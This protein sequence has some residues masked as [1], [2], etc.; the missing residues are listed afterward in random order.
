LG[1]G[2]LQSNT[3]GGSNSAMGVNALQTN[4]TGNA[5]S[6]LGVNALQFNLSGSNN[7]AMGASSLNAN[8][9]GSSNT[10]LGVSALQN[11]TIGGS[12]SAM[13]MNA[14][15]TNIGGVNNSALGVNALRYNTEGSNNAAVGVS[16][17]QNNTTGGNNTAIGR[18]AGLN[19]TTSFNVVAIGFSALSSVT[20]SGQNSTAVGAFALNLATV[21]GNTALGSE[22]GLTTTTGTS[23]IYLGHRAGD[24]TAASASNR[25][26]AGSSDAAIVSV[27]IGNGETNGSPQA[28]TY[29]ATGGSGTNIGGAA[30]TLAGGRNT[31]SGVGG[32]VV[33][34]TTAVG[35][36]SATAGTLLNRFS[37]LGDGGVLWTGIATASEPAV[38]TSNNGAIFFDA[39]LQKFRVSQNGAAYVDL[40]GGGGTVTSV[41]VTTANGVSGS[42]AT[43][44]TTPAITITLGAIT[45]T[46]VAS[47]GAVS[48]TTGTFS[49]AVAGSNLSG[50]NTGDQTITLT[51]NVTGSGTGSFATTIA[52]S[53]VT[54]AMQANVATS[55]ILGRVTA[56]TG[57]VEALTGTQATTLLDSFTSALKGLAPASGGGTTN[58]LRADG[59]WVAPAGVPGGS[60]T[61][62]QFNNAG[63]FGASANFAYTVSTG[64]LGLS[65]AVSTSGSPTLL[66]L[67]GA[68]HTTLTAS[69]EA[70]DIH[71]NLART[72]QFATG[73]I[74]SQRAVRVSAPTYSFVGASTIT[75]AATFAI[76][77]S[78]GIGAN[79]TATN[80]YALWVEAGDSFFNGPLTCAQL[81]STT[82]TEGR[83]PRVTTGGQITDTAFL[84]LSG[85]G[86]FVH[87]GSSNFTIGTGTTTIGGPTI[88]TYASAVDL[89]LATTGTGTFNTAITFSSG[90]T[91]YWLQGLQGGT[92]GSKDWFLYDFVAGDTPIFVEDGA[93]GFISFARPTRVTNTTAS[94]STITGALT[95]AGGLGVAGQVSAA[96]LLASGLTSGRVPFVAAGGLLTDGTGLLYSSGTLT[97]GDGSAASNLILNGAASVNKAIAFQAAGLTMWAIR[98]STASEDLAIRAN[99]AAGAFIDS[100]I[101]IVRA[102]GGAITFAR[103]TTQATNWEQTGA[104]TLSTGTGA[105]SLNGDTTIPGGKTLTVASDTDATTILG[106]AVISSPTTDVAYFSHFDR[107]NA[108]SYAILQDSFGATYVN[109]GAGQ[110]MRLRIA[111]A[112]GL[113]I[114]ATSG[115]F[116]AGLAVSVANTTASTSTITGALTVAG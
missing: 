68:A 72:V 98:I 23:N 1:V 11:N 66:T 7:T 32:A 60:D 50:T 67:T 56:A 2:A 96:T 93:G 37:I 76:S 59:T 94:T 27:F 69:T 55:T 33:I 102:A 19:V 81:S 41:S 109:A 35:A 15:Q 14:L 100:P 113:S 25:L 103:P 79:A 3:T 104:T 61:Q 30:L 70:T 62:V 92:T 40:V 28:I 47:S 83:I 45:P 86:T 116:A 108:T 52:A 90:G 78:P 63:A 74:T 24:S 73:D 42:V 53:A 8:T 75:T 22:A 54:L 6:A 13:G 17:L 115:A 26:V 21:A 84:T 87:S 58:F 95:V 105:N 39:T 65:Q 107:A 101:S 91:S 18:D 10:S 36:S 49:G 9:T 31:G 106:R 38:S 71:A 5:N 89:T 85:N 57:V 111:N 12:N 80:R 16:A 48:G 97:A 34:Q 4:T 64:A 44:T 99:D 82:L 112:N 114:S 46:S 77:G 43:A 88:I 110:T 29:N 51:G 20:T